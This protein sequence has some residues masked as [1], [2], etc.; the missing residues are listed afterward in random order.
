[1]TAISHGGSTDAPRRPAGDIIEEILRFMRANLEP[2]KYSTLAPSRYVVYLHPNEYAR[3]EGILPILQEQT[4]RALT[5]E[6]EKLNHRTP[7]RRYLERFLAGQPKVENAATDWHVEF[8]P[9]PDGEIGDGD[10]LIDAELLLPARP[11]LGLGERTRRITTLNTG[12]RSTTRHYTVNR[13]PAGALATVHARLQYE[14]NTGAHSFDITRDST[15]V[16][17]GG[18]AYRVDVR[19]EAS[20]DVSREHF[21]IRRDPQTGRFFIIDL[22]SLGTTVD[23]RR[24]PSGYEETDGAKRENGVE[25]PLPDRARIGMADTVYVDFERTSR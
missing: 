24:L 5:E 3:I 23:G 20:A 7:V 2:L 6:L 11:E 1:M 4:L 16:G 19:I 10:I 17:R 14:D 25:T 12:R 8:L 13:A 9:D 22:S 18:I 21:R 15:S